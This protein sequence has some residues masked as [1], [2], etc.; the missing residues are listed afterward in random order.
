M[1]PVGVVVDRAGRALVALSDGRIAL[2]EPSGWS[3]TEVTDEAPTEH[4]GPPP[5]TSS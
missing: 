2:R 1:T 3:T 5:A 4:P